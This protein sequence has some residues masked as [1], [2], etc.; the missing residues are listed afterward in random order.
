MST[1]GDRC[2]PSV[3]EEWDPLTLG[4]CMDSRELV[5]E[6]NSIVGHPTFGVRSVA[7]KQKFFWMLGV[8]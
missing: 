4:V 6:L 8:F 5:S 7:N 1:L 3:S 2:L